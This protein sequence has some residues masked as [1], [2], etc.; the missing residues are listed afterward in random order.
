MSEYL[1]VLDGVGKCF[2]RDRRQWRVLRDISLRVGRG[3]VVGVYGAHGEGKTTLLEVAAGI[4]PPDEGRVWFEGQDLASLSVDERVGLLGDR[5]AWMNRDGVDE[6]T[7][8]KSVSLPLSMGR[9]YTKRE[10]D[11]LAMEALDRVGMAHCAK[12]TWDR[13]SNWERVLVTFA[14]GFAIRPRLMVVDDLLDSLGVGGVR[15]AGELLLSLANELRCSVLVAAAGTEALLIA[16]RV[17]SF[18]S[19]TLTPKESKVIHLNESRVAGHGH[20]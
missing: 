5:I 14:R 17:L 4:E 2:R 7:A 8:L 19:G 20:G 13:L 11:D 10:A 18:E 9:G 6:F 1:L 3:E 12:Q 15:E 16:D